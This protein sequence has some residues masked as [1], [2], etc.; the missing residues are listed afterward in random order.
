MVVVLPAPFGPSRPTTVPSGTRKSTPSSAVND[1]NRLTNPSASTPP[2]THLCLV[3]G[4]AQGK[5]LEAA[6]RQRSELRR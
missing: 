6:E 3:R 2:G 4:A 5:M 1:P